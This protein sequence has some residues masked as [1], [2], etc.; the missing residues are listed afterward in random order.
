[1]RLVT[2]NPTVG[3]GTGNAAPVLSHA[4]ISSFSYLFY[5]SSPDLPL[6]VSVT[7]IAAEVPPT[8]QGR[9]VSVPGD[10]E[11][12]SPEGDRVRGVV[13]ASELTM[14]LILFHTTTI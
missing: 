11:V 8:V 2:P 4:T 10:Y 5:L 14:E 13:T 7:V 6:V 3:N 12:I 9:S 1:M